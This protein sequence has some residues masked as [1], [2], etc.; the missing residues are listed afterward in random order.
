M[1]L[2]EQIRFAQPKDT[3]A[4]L[5]IYA[6]Y[7]LHTGLSFEVEV[8]TLEAFQARI[9]GIMAE[10]PYLVYEVDG[11]VVGYAYAGKHGERAAFSYD[12]NLSVYF[13]EEFHSKGKA[14]LLYLALFDLLKAQGFFNAY[15]AYAEPN[16]KS[17]RFHDK[18]GFETVG[19]FVK[20]GYKL[21]K[22]H[23]LTWAAKALRPHSD[24]P[25][26]ILNISQLSPTL[27]ED[28][29]HKYCP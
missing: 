3:Q 19:T 26:S 23:D 1:V 16:P 28:T 5:D 27:I 14:K 4:I 25:S 13:S 10:Y 22:W 21:G 8:P 29:F 18:L 6:P 17:Q 9:Q 20:T 2:Q 7:I 15:V 12:V 11:Q 24:T